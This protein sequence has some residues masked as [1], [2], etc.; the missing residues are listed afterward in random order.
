MSGAA[1]PLA[2]LKV[3][4]FSELLPGPFLSQ[5]LAEMGAEVLKV[6]RPPQ[7]D[8]ARTLVP[9]VFAAMNR[10]KR[11]IFL[12]LKDEAQRKDAL[13]L[14][15]RADI[16]LEGYRPGVM[17][18][19]GLDYDTVQTR[20]PRVIYVSITGYGQT[21]P[22]AKLAGHDL[23]YL[24]ASGVTALSGRA[25]EA[26]EHGYGIPVADL[27]GSL[28]GLAATLA[29]LEQRH[30]TGRGQWLDVSIADC[31]THMMNPRIGQFVAKGQADL[32]AQRDEALLRP[33]YGV[34]RTADG[35]YLAIAAVEDH[36][37]N[38]LVQVLDLKI[39]DL[40]AGTF[41]A[42]TAKADLVNGRVAERIAGFEATELRERLM[43][44]DLPW[45]DVVEPSRLAEHPQQ[46]ARGKLQTQ[47]TALG[48][49]TLSRFP[50]SLEGMATS[51]FEE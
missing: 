49:M 25:G 45:S 37:W 24:A 28:Y 41:T 7:G 22:L 39:D 43:Q 11:S 27:S 9:G 13:A 6:E 12:D 50:V 31:L 26:P 51:D 4:D 42:R 34:F 23:N 14:A 16:V 44:A 5:C 2:G 46:R 15:A 33:G 8:N 17:A 21:G 47:S 30:R 20:N 35:A 1:A 19:L 38:R 48:E 29:A 3:V 36:F 18:R 32:R 10:G 40:D